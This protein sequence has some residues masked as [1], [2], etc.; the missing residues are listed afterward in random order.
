M[1]KYFVVFAEDGII[2]NMGRADGDGSVV[3]KFKQP[4]LKSGDKIYFSEAEDEDN[5]NHEIEEN[6]KKKT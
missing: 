1:N 4:K 5:M 3:P 6:K 2:K